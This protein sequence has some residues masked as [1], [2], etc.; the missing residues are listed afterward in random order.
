M[1][2]KGAYYADTNGVPKAAGRV[3]H[4]G[5]AAGEL[6]NRIVSVGSLSRAKTLRD[7]LDKPSEAFELTSDRGFTTY[8]GTFGG[9]R[10]SI[11]AT[12]MGSPMMDFLVREARAS[13]SGPMLVVRY[14]SCG[15]L[16]EDAL[17]GTVVVNTTGAVYVQRNYD[18]FASEEGKGKKR[19]AAGAAPYLVSRKV[20]PDATL[21]ASARDA[22]R[23]ALGGKLVEGLNASAD[24]F[25]GSQ[26][27]IDANFD[28]R[29]D[30]VVESVQAEHPE[31]ASME[32]ESFQLLHLARCALPAGAVRAA[33]A[34]I[35]CANRGSADVI[36]KE[37]LH[38]LE[39]RGGR[40]MLKAVTS[41]ALGLGGDP[42]P[43]AAK[44]KA[45][46]RARR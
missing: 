24:S 28:D 38:D 7:C 18:A 19:S 43:P 4:L 10:V 17:P 39:K 40:A 20:A 16:R 41:C 2:K 44:G 34:A 45:S 42:A 23:D 13:V 36:T 14:G 3:T 37:A 21:A 9:E 25:Y 29:N 15:G 26:G 5:V 11:V 12:G 6:A 30:G 33:T 1:P 22:L 31:V 27:R 35:V 32:M 8:T 46:K